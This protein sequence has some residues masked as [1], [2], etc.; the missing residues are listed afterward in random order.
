MTLK[1]LLRSVLRHDH[2]LGGVITAVEQESARA[3]QSIHSV[4]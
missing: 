1:S 3:N 2:G 4:S